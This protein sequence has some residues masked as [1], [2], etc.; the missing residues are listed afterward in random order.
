MQQIQFFWG[1]V[2]AK[3]TANSRNPDYLK[4]FA[5]AWTFA[6]QKFRKFQMEILKIFVF[7]WIRSNLNI[8]FSLRFEKLRFMQS[9]SSNDGRKKGKDCGKNYAESLISSIQFN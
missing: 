8:S 5:S 4:R 6:E 9:R 7:K 3:T 2:L 1:K